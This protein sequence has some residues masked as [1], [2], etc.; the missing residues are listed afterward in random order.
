MPIA[1]TPKRYK[2]PA[3][4]LMCCFEKSRNQWKAKHHQVKR[5]QKQLQKQMRVL[6]KRVE[7]EKSRAEALEAEVTRLRVREQALVREVERLER[8]EP[9]RA[10]G[11]SERRGWA[12]APYHHAYR[13]GQIE[14]FLALV[15]SAAT[16]LRCAARVIEL[17]AARFGL[18]LP[19][20]SWSAGRVWLLRV[21]YYKLTRPK[22]LAEDWVW[23]VDHTV[24]VGTEK[25][26]VILGLRLC[27][28]PPAGRSLSHAD[29]EPIA[30][31]PVTHSDGDVVY[32][33]LEQATAQTGVPREIISDHGTDVKAGIEKFCDRHPQTSA[34]YDIK[35]KTAAVLKRE[36]EHDPAWPTF[37]QQASR[38]QSQLR[39]TDL[40]A[41]APPSQKTKARYMNVDELVKW[42]QA[43]LVLLDKQPNALCLMFAP[44]QVKQKLGWVTE[45]RTHL[46]MWGEMFQVI[47]T[48]ESCI[49]QQGLYAGAQRDLKKRL[50]G[51]T[52]TEPARRI[53]DELVAFVAQEEQA[54]HPDERLLGSSEVIESVLGTMKRLEQQQAKS[55]FTSLILGLCAM[56]ADTTQEI[57]QAALETVP[58]KKV[59][60]WCQKTLGHSVQAK[61]R[62]ALRPAE[63]E[64]KRV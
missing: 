58:T 48:A 28:L 37:T 46:A 20:P 55:G 33:Q 52:H 53:R 21:G 40:A 44:G 43:I 56:V 1:E 18:S 34:V 49:R 51:L 14:L 24:Q 63:A 9:E 7:R 12:V 11:L 2:S 5:Q 60:A 50:R 54:A 17:V 6:E 62:A 8:W 10:V 26:L 4:K 31:L 45:Y 57:I 59:W 16:S 41:L 36:L 25:C 29:V 38:T 47:A 15:I 35:H 39:Q 3:R 27:D 19:C 23:I 64:Q 22:V 30:L 42:G 13:L 61:R 32:Q